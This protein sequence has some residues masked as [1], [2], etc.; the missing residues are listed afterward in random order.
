[1]RLRLWLPPSWS[2]LRRHAHTV[3][4]FTLY[5]YERFFTHNCLRHASTLSYTTLL[6]IV[7]LMTVAFTILAAFPVFEPVNERVRLFIFANLVPTSGEVV[8][9]YLERFAGQAARLTAAGII[10]LLVSALLMMAAVDRA[11]NEIWHVQTRRF[12]V[13]GFMIYWTLLTI[14]P[15]LMGASLI[16]TSYLESLQALAVFGVSGR[17]QT[18]LNVMPIVAEFLAFLFLYSAVPNRRIPFRHAA[19]GALLAALLFELAKK[20]FTWY[21]TSFPTYEAIYGALAALPVFLVWV[22]LSWIVVLM[23]AVFTQALSSFHV[24]RGG[25]LS[26]P[27]LRLILV[28]RLIGHLWYA[29][30]HGRPVTRRGLAR[31]EP[32]AG[33]DVIQEVLE[34]LERAKIVLRTDRGAWALARDPSHYTLLDLYRSQSLGLPEPTPNFGERDEWDRRLAQVLRQANQDVQ[35]SL[36]VPIYNL[37]ANA[38]RS[39]L[40]ED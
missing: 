15:L 19:F 23:G 3:Y 5:L 34:K 18:L 30:R 10:G 6:S 26:D 12:S 39:Q 25:A 33:E 2:E 16:A 40:P 13:Q 37:F 28:V 21:V 38:P 20:A 29:Q 9:S 7:P 1:M 35:E 8:Q 4:E 36:N 27:R 22:Y 32:G 24:G 14:G 11:L 31:R 17:K